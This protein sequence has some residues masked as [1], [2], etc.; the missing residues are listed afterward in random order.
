VDADRFRVHGPRILIE[1]D[2]QGALSRKGGH[3][4]AITCEPTNDYGM[5][6]LGLHY[7]ERPSRAVPVAPVARAGCPLAP[8]RRRAAVRDRSPKY[9]LRGDGPI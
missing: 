9:T 3:V 6:W 7:Q 4:H 5:D 8:C 2:L 1:Y